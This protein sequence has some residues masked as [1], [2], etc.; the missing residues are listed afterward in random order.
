VTTVVHPRLVHLIAAPAADR[1]AEE[2]G[3]GLH[4]RAIPRVERRIAR[5]VFDARTERRRA[6]ARVR[7]RQGGAAGRRCRPCR[8]RHVEEL[9]PRAH[10]QAGGHT[11]QPLDASERAGLLELDRQAGT[12]R[13][14]TDAEERVA[15]IGVRAERPQPDSVAAEVQRLQRGGAPAP[16]ARPEAA[17]A[18][19][20]RRRGAILRVESVDVAAD[21]HR[22]VFERRVDDRQRCDDP[23]APL[24]FVPWRRLLLRASGGGQKNGH[25]P[26]HADGRPRRGRTEAHV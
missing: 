4:L 3:D 14:L 26:H 6:Q 24:R 21:Q 25:G 10:P 23:L 17:S 11:H 7:R 15:N 5:I 2:A 12:A 22:S 8:D 1:L 19:N 9:V 16:V 20:R 13:G 18:G